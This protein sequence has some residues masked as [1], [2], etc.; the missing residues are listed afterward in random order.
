MSA[1]VRIFYEVKDENF[2]S[3]K[4]I[5]KFVI[6][7]IQHLSKFNKIRTTFTSVNT[8]KMLFT[9]LRR[10]AINNVVSYPLCIGY[11]LTRNEYTA[12]ALYYAVT[13]H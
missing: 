10:L 11:T 12:G 7:F 13:V 8:T 2:H 1:M 5:N 9:L 3:M 6:C 4:Q